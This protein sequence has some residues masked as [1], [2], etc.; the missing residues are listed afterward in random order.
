[1]ASLKDARALADELR[2]QAE[3]IVAEFD[4]NVDFGR[5]VSLADE[6]GQASDRFAV[7]FHTIDTAFASRAVGTAPPPAEEREAPEDEL[8]VALV[9]PTRSRRRR[10]QA[11]KSP[12]AE[13]TEPAEEQTE[14]TE[15]ESAASAARATS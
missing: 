15:Q 1:M 9:V 4:G 6:L 3:T 10:G 14:Q 7:T 13:A 12:T 8:A 2:E 11:G 5:L